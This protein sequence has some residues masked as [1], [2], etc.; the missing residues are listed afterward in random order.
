MILLSLK[1]HLVKKLMFSMSIVILM[2]LTPFLFS[3]EN[4]GAVNRQ[5]FGGFRRSLTPRKVEAATIQ[6]FPGA[7]GF[8]AYSKGGRGGKVFHVT[9]L[10]DGGYGET[11]DPTNGSTIG[12]VELYQP[13]METEVVHSGDQSVPIMYDNSAANLSEVTVSTNDLAIGSDWTKGGAQTLVLWFYGDP[14]NSVTEQMYLK[15]NGTTVVY[16]GDPNN[17]TKRRW[18]QWNI[19][20]ASLG[21]NPGNVTTLTIGFERTGTTGGLGTVFIDDIRLYRSAAPV[22]EPVD[23]GDA[24]LVAY[25]GMNNNVQD[26]SGNGLHGTIAGAPTYVAGVAGTA[27]SLDGVD[28]YVDCGNKA[29]FNPAGSLSI[30]LW[31]NIGAWSTEWDHAM[32]SNRGEG[33]VGWQVRRYSNDSLCFTTRGVGSDDTPS[34]MN[35]PLNEWVHIACVYDNVNNTKRIHINGGEDTVVTTNPGTISATTH[36]T[37]IGARANDGNTAP[38]AYFT[39]MFDEIRI[40]NRALSDGEVLYLADQY[41]Q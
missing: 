29:A 22:P 16:D 10:E 25:Y 28:D 23:P 14:N 27:L 31:A 26:S 19:D 36:N 24:D 6:A 20:L 35:P 7:E 9:T 41:T 37:Y 30:S 21:V 8:G 32:V 17:I 3:Q 13:T 12:Y 11:N 5:R 1:G 40:Y 18:N 4:R 33:S 15:I 2:I 39:G 38:E 34:N